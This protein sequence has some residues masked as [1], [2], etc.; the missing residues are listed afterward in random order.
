MDRFCWGV[1]SSSVQTEGVHPSADWSRWERD[2]RV[3]ES[4]DGNGFATNFHDD[5]ALIASLGFSDVRLTLEWARIEPVAGKVDSQALDLYSDIVN[6][7]RSV[8][9]AP[10][11]TLVHTTLPGWFSDDSGSFIDQSSRELTWLRHVDRCAERFGDIAEGWVPI[12]DPIGWALRGYGLGSRP[13]GKRSETDVGKALLSDS[14]EAALL[15]DHLAAR[16]LRR[17]GATTM[18]VRGTPTIFTVL[19]D[20]Q[21]TLEADAAA[22]HVRWWAAVLFDSW[23]NMVGNGELVLPNRRPLHDTQWVDDFDLVGLA[24]DHPIGLNHLGQLRPYPPSATTADSGFAPLPEELGVLLHRISDR[25]PTTDLII[26]AHG[27]ATDN[28]RWR[29]ELLEEALEI[30]ASARE[31]GLRLRGFFHDTAIDGYEWKAGFESERGLIGRDRRPRDSA[32]LFTNAI[33]ASRAESR[34]ASRE[35]STGR[36]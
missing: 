34:E 14:L 12:D 19:D 15:A 23:I 24:F 13:P 8:G 30:V 22:T 20:P 2:K 16:H 33:G 9:L 36:S 11:L 29:H 21:S 1:T 17:G 18:A 35:P 5:L 26:A 25:L 28:D 4:S 27:V 10:W 6:H 32:D 3:P 31:D 7:A